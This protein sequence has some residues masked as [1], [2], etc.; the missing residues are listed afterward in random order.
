MNDTSTVARREVHWWTPG[1]PSCCRRS[2]H[3]QQRSY[4]G[5]G[6]RHSNVNDPE[7]SF[8]HND[9][10]ES[11]CIVDNGKIA[12]LIDWEM[13]GFFSWNTAG[14]VHRRIR[15]QGVFC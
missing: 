11:N 8:M 4:P 13:A 15:T 2:Q 12:G 10:T 3:S 1:S 9:F 14:E 5:P 7:M 6:R